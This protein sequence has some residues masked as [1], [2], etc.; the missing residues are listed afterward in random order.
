[1][2]RRDFFLKC[3]HARESAINLSARQ[4]TEDPLYVFNFGNAV[5]N[6]CQIVSSANREMNRLFESVSVQNRT[7]VEIIGHYE[8]IENKF[9]T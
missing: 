8:T 4:R 2:R 1:M 5:T 3:R 9:A 6:H 7:H